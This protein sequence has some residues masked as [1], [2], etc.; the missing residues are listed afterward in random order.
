MTSSNQSLRPFLSESVPSLLPLSRLA[1]PPLNKTPR[2]NPRPPSIDRPPLF[3]RAEMVPVPAFHAKTSMVFSSPLVSRAFSPSGL[4]PDFGSICR[5]KKGICSLF[6]LPNDCETFKSPA[7]LFPFSF[8]H[9]V[10][11]SSLAGPPHTLSLRPL[12]CRN[13]RR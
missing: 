1:L 4:V 6:L 10:T 11:L 7:F 2:F 5:G 12:F 8:D 13:W 3:R 9:D